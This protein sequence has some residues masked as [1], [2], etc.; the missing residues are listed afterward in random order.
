MQLGLNG[1]VALITGGSSGLGRAAARA[2]ATEGASVAIAARGAERLEATA[3]E[4]RTIAGPAR[5][6]AVTADVRSPDQV[7]TMVQQV[8]ERFGG[9]DILLNNAGANA[10]GPFLELDDATWQVDFDLK[11]FAAVRCARACI[12]HMRARGGGRIVNVLS[13]TA[14]QP[15]GQNMPTAISRAAGLAFTKSLSK[16]F[17]SDRILVNAVLVGVVKSNQWERVHAARPDGRTIDDMYAEIGEGIPL[18]RVGEAEE[19]GD[20]VAFLVS[21]RASYITGAAINFDGGRAV[22]P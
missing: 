8:V 6:F 18:G 17:A 4:L 1:R 7:T 13:I 15:D 2:L 12:P 19:F 22:V 5:V 21:D 10:A 20:L 3:D 11:L 9:L 14:R 16:A